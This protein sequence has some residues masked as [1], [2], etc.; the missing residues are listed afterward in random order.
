MFGLRSLFTKIPET[1]DSGSGTSKIHIRKTDLQDLQIL[2]WVGQGIRTQTIPVLVAPRM[3]LD[4][5]DRLYSV[6]VDHV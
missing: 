6:C 2:K 4:K 1:P 3:N 5:S